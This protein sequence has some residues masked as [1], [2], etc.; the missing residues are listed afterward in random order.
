ML[1]GDLVT[2]S[3]IVLN[4]QLRLLKVH[5]YLTQRLNPPVLATRDSIHLCAA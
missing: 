3:L 1:Q 2:S 5:S 4:T